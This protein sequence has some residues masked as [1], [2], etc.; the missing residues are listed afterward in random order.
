MVYRR[1]R[2]HRRVASGNDI[3]PGRGGPP[4]MDHSVN[5]DL[6]I[7]QVGDDLSDF[8]ASPMSQRDADSRPRPEPRPHARARHGGFERAIGRA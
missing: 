2:H 7:G 1:I 6:A 4:S 3:A 5:D 8:I